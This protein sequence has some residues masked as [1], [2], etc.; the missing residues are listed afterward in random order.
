MGGIA[1]RNRAWKTLHPALCKKI[2]TVFQQDPSSPSP[3][4]SH[5]F[6]TTTTTKPALTIPVLLYNLKSDA[7]LPLRLPVM[8]DDIKAIA[9][10]DTRA[11]VVVLGGGWLA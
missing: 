4:P 3:P 6:T 8:I 9:Y 5:P 11:G 2:L 1:N 7:G 10:L